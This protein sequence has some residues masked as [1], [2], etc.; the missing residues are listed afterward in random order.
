MI[1][2]P[3][4]G[5]R[6]WYWPSQKQLDEGVLHSEDPQQAMD[7]GVIFVHSDRRVNLIVTDH[8][9]RLLFLKE[10][11]L[12]QDGD[13]VADTAGKATWM[14]YQVQA[15]EKSEVVR[16]PATTSKEFNPEAGKAGAPAAP[17]NK[18]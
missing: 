1:I 14:P 2:K 12:V 6:V 5:R 16:P 18:K 8:W 11:H 10:V 3:T 15:A 4:I 7:A 13:V 17:L 9:G